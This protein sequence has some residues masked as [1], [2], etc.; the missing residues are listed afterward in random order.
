MVKYGRHLLFLR[1]RLPEKLYL[2]DYKHVQSLIGETDGFIRAWKEALQ[3]AGD[4]K[5]VMMTEL[6]SEVFDRVTSGF[7]ANERGLRPVVALRLY[8]D[9]MGM[10][11]TQ[12]LI[13]NYSEART[14]C[15]ANWEALRKLV[16]KFDKQA[17]EHG[18]EML[19]QRLLPLLYASTLTSVMH[20]DD[21]SPFEAMKAELVS[22]VAGYSTEEC[23]SSPPP[24]D[25][26]GSPASGAASEGVP[27]PPPLT[28]GGSGGEAK[29]ASP[30]APSMMQSL[31]HA[32]AR[33]ASALPG[34]ALASSILSHWAPTLYSSMQETTLAPPIRERLNEW[35][36]AGKL[37]ASLS[38]QAELSQVERR[39]DELA[40]LR[41]LTSHDIPPADLSH[42]VAHR[43]F[44]SIK[45]RSDRRPIENSLEA[46]ELAWTSGVKLCECDVAVTRDG[47]LVLG[48]DADYSRLALKVPGEEMK[49]HLL[50]GQLTLAELVAMPLKSG[51]R[52]PTLLEVLRS[53]IMIGN[54]V[55][56]VIEIKPGNVTAADALVELISAHP[57][58]IPA[59]GVV[60]S[61]DAFIMG[62]FAPKLAALA[63]ARGAN[64][65]HGANTRI[66]RVN[67]ASIARGSIS[68]LKSSSISTSRGKLWSAVKKVD[69]VRG[70]GSPISNS[71]PARL[72]QM[73]SAA[74]A[75]HEHAKST[76]SAR[77]SA[78]GD[79]TTS[80]ASATSDTQ[81]ETK[82]RVTPLLEPLR[83]AQL[84]LPKLL[85]LT[86]AD[87]PQFE[88][89]H[90]LDIN[91]DTA[92]VER[93]ADG[94]DGVYIE[95]QK[96]MLTPE[97][98]ATMRAMAQRRHVGVW[99]RAG[100]HP[101]HLSTAQTLIHE[102]GATY[103]NTDLPTTFCLSQ[104]PRVPSTPTGSRD[105][106]KQ[107]PSA[108][109]AASDRSPKPSP[110]TSAERLQQWPK[111]PA[112]A[113]ER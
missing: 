53:A 106:L 18:R 84:P 63:E 112:E 45:D 8:H 80:A 40:W 38:Q 81:V 21:L 96:E 26:G 67:R 4:A 99:T 29:A 71:V 76:D 87:K 49:T 82:P 60:M 36:K 109:N 9:T 23:P 88:F 86:V 92:P 61:F 78:G 12:R 47:T 72:D 98:Q 58:V 31:A 91:V 68:S 41:S 2:V 11:E 50:V 22:G 32:V 105:R 16:K 59:I 65:R 55:Q 93:V 15:I 44:H 95:F 90:W 79:S 6:W 27:S 17:M 104:S 48:H 25:F 70:L 75:A 77:E 64:H 42:L 107:W 73:N 108:S 57:E 62:D 37:R 113:E 110:A 66:S 3:A 28:L 56:L 69:A 5:E 33:R 83:S 7:D 111:A 94:L 1:Q 39:A 19:S 35:R 51:S 103:V 10:H 54:D 13:D 85:L 20:A 102:C 89:E 34:A 43:G 52:P 97:G 46:Y 24:P 14:S 30:A 100:V 101:D 74:A